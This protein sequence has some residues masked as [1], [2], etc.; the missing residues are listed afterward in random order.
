MSFFFFN[1]NESFLLGASKAKE[2]IFTARKFD[3]KAALALGIVGTVVDAGQAKAEA[4][5]IAR[6]IAKRGPLAV[7]AAK[8]AIDEGIQQVSVYPR[9]MTMKEIVGILPLL[10]FVDSVVLQEISSY[11]PTCSLLAGWQAFLTRTSRTLSD[12]TSCK[13]FHFLVSEA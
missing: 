5:S 9:R 4:L 10:L 12:T 8:E 2:L 6:E 1:V 13:L 3:A 7:R 11:V